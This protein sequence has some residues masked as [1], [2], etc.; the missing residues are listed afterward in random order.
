MIDKESLLQEYRVNAR[1]IK[2]AQTRDPNLG[3][4]QLLPGT[5]KNTDA[6]RGRGWNLIALPFVQDGVR[7]NYRLLMN[8]YNEELKLTFIDDMVPNRGIATEPAPQNTDQLVVTLDYQQKIDQI[9]ADDR[10][11]SGLAGAPGLAIHHEPGLFL[12]MKNFRTDGFDIARLATIPHGNAATAIGKSRVIDGPP[13]IPD[14]SGFPEGA[15]FGNIVTAVNEATNEES[16]LFPYNFYTNNP[17]KGELEGTP[18]PGFSP[19]NPNALLQGGLPQ[20]VIRTTELDMTTEALEAG[21]RNI[22]FIEQQA[23]AEVMRSTFWIMELDEMD[24][25]GEPKL[26]MAY[27]Q[28]I[29]LDFFDRR[30]GQDGLI[31]WP[32][33]SINV[34]EKVKEASKED[35]YLSTPD[36][37]GV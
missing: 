10:P 22:P 5:W 4:L 28:F 26:M 35:P 31:R 7:R 37:P 12:H 13:T 17:F 8:Q 23:D 33:V 29:F 34:M 1:T 18:F 16:Y 24:E 27:S 11:L 6:L 21:I 9:S 14:I 19:A 32:H 36:L 25:N 3:P 30:D 2:V 15:V 20:N